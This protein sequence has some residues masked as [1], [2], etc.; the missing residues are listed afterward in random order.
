MN[1]KEVWCQLSMDEISLKSSID[2]DVKSDSF[3]G[4]VT[5]PGHSGKATKVLCFQLGGFN[6]RWKQYHYTGK[7]SFT[8]SVRFC[9][10]KLNFFLGD[11]VDGDV[12]E[13]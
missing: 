13:I 2:Y 7:T 6:S 3:I 9:L 5:L 12:R 1:E 4:I 10:H 11:S 8:Y